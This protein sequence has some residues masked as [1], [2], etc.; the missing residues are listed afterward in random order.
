MLVHDCLWC[1]LVEIFLVDLK[2][3]IETGRYRQ[4]VRLFKQFWI[5]YAFEFL[6]W[7]C[8][9]LVYSDRP[10]ATCGTVWTNVVLYLILE[11]D[12]NYDV[13]LAESWNFSLWHRQTVLQVCVLVSIT[14]AAWP[15]GGK[16]LTLEFTLMLW[17]PLTLAIQTLRKIKPSW[18]L[19]L[20]SGLQRYWKATA[21]A[22]ELNFVELLVTVTQLHIYNAFTSLLNVA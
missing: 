22:T 6:F 13:S 21:D 1:A 2:T 19:N 17:N 16:N 14:S 12:Q 3:E 7:C 20:F 18:S 5:K 9:M 8:Q 10:K 4:F 15:S 11:N